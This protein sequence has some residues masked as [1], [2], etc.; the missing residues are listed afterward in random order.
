MSKKAKGV[1]SFQISSLIDP[2]LTANVI[3]TQQ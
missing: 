3:S 2:H 1:L